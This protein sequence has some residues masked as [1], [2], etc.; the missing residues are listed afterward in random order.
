LEEPYRFAPLGEQHLPM[1]GLFSCGE[2]ALDRYLQQRARKEMEQRIALVWVLIDSEA[3]RIAGYYTLSAI[4]VER[5]DLPP[6][7]TH[8]L[9]RYEAYPATLIGRLAVDRDYQD[10]RIGG[11]LLLDAL[12]RCLDVSRKVASVAVVTDAKNLDVQGFYDHYGFM[13]L[14]T[15]T[16]ERRLFLPMRTVERLFAER[17]VT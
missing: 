14:P 15:E 6:E 9:A 2:E 4:A 13:L 8:R 10:K 16:H 17:P 11:R 7:F 3:D 5:V 12:A 1:R